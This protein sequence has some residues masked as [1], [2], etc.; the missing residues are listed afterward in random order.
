M[1]EI[2]LEL[3][4]LSSKRPLEILKSKKQGKKVV[5]FYGDFIPEQWIVAAGMEPYLICK[6]GDPQPPEATLDLMVRFMNPLAATMA[7][8]YLMG[9]DAVMPIADCVAVQQHDAH[10]GRMTEILEYKGLPV[11]KVGVPAD[12]TVGISQDYYR[13]E[14]KEF[15]EKLEALGGQPI[16]DDAIRA[17]YA[18]TNKINELL[19]KIDALRKGDSSPI[20]FADFLRINHY[21]FH[22]DYDTSIA[23]LEK[24]Y[25]YLKDAPAVVD[26]KAPR[27]LA[28]GRAFAKGDYQVPSILEQA[29][30]NVVTEFMDEAIRPFHSDISLEGDVIDAY[31]DAMYINRVP[32]CI[33]QPS[34][35]ARAE[36]LKKLIEENKIDAVLWYQLAFDEIY[37]MEYAGIAKDLNAMRIPM[38]KLESSYE[39]SREALAPL[40]TRLESFVESLKEE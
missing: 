22:V 24:I 8:S 4:R 33:F 15:R 10:Y 1:K 37:D 21:T 36:H 23:A 29:G 25:D 7:G 11:Y 9:L 5:E 16:S 2:M 12:Y 30:A 17:Q 38:L 18:K 3:D 13:N 6:G 35:D 14:L 32:Q 27:I 40:V 34:W 31:V 19:R 39:Y 20:S 28:M 26:V